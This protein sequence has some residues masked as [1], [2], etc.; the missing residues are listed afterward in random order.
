M[1]VLKEEH[2]TWPARG[3]RQ[4]G[5]SFQLVCLDMSQP[6]SDRMGHMVTYRLSPEEKL[7]FWGKCADQT[8]N[9]ALTRIQNTGSGSVVFQ[10]RII[11]KK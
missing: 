6:P 8:L 11:P 5:E 1:Q 7:Q 9:F 2:Q 10:G 3:D 4:A